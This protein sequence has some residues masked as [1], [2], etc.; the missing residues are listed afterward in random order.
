[1][2][3]QQREQTVSEIKTR[4]KDAKGLI[5]LDYKGLNVERATVLRRQI[6]QAGAELKVT[7]NTLL[8]IATQNTPYE[9]LKETLTGQTAVAIIDRDPAELAKS[10]AKFLKDNKDTSLS[11]KA[12]VVEGQLLNVEE[13]NQLGDLPSKEVLL[14]QLVGIL[15]SPMRGLVTTLSDIPGKFLRV[16]SAIAD[17][18]EK[19]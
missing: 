5:L 17:Q 9:P 1:M 18:K 3:R 10:L 19:Q 2:S 11:I 4:I 12:G 16:L 8:S 7:K 6:R 14:G 15:S 13:I